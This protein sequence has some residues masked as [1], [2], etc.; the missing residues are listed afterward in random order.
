MENY[1]KLFFGE[2]TMTI[3]EYTLMNQSLIEDTNATATDINAKVIS[4]ALQSFHV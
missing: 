4:T 3:Y 1:K 2:A